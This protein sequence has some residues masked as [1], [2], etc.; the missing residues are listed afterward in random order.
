[1]ERASGGEDALAPPHTDWLRHDLVV[2]GPPADV[3]AFGT[4]AAG[5]GAIPWRYADL[6]LDEEDRVHALLHP[7]DGSAGLR[8]A[9]ARVLARQLRGAVELHQDRVTEAVGRSRLCPFDLHALLPVPESLL[10]QGPDDPGS[11]AW[12]R[13]NWGVIRALRHVRLLDD[14]PDRRRRHSA[15]LRYEFW[16]ADWTPWAAFAG[17]HKA[18]PSLVFDLRP[19]YDDG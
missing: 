12:L 2:T 13:A 17:L 16:S 11:L 8:L 6:D 7:P 18:W 14:P 5:A 4:A 10:H 1:M 19:D 9:A 15:R 3:A